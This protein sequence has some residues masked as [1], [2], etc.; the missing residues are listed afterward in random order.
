MR[1]TIVALLLLTGC[2]AADTFEVHAPRAVSARLEVCGQSVFLARSGDLFRLD[3]RSGCEGGGTIV[4]AFPE[5]AP[6]TCHVGY[7]A[8]GVAQRFRF[9]VDGGRCSAVD[10]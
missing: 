4:L 1:N 6:V 2:G 9:R 10:G 7:V 5:G 8:P 3:H